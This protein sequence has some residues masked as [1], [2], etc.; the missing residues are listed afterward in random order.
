VFQ[1]VNVPLDIA[2]YSNA[3]SILQ[4]VGNLFQSTT[5]NTAGVG[6]A[7]S[8][9]YSY[10]LDATSSLASALTAGVGPK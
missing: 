4:P 10:A 7:F 1:G 9:S 2:D 8:P 5:G 3:A 6:T